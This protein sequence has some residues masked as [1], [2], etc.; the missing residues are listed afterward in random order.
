MECYLQSYV[1]YQQ[2]DWVDWLPM[3]EFAGNRNY[4]QT[5]RISPF[6]ANYGFEPRMS[7]DPVLQI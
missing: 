4:S 1:N 6:M 2:D 7:F 5:T 3:A